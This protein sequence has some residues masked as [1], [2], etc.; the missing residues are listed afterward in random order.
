MDKDVIIQ[1]IEYH[2]NKKTL[3]LKKYTKIIDLDYLKKNPVQFKINNAIIPYY[4]M[5]D[6][7]GYEYE[8]DSYYPASYKLTIEFRECGIIDTK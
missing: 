3:K 6:L 4:F 7:T 2:R 1:D 8:F 5:M